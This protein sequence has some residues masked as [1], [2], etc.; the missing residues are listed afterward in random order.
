ML[1]AVNFNIMRNSE[2]IEGVNIIAKY[3]PEDE[4]QSSGVYAEHDQFW[5][6]AEEWVTD[7]NDIKRLD[8][9]GWFIDECGWSGWA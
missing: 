7:E 9:L 3:I 2:F 6:G 8:E 4:K 5:F 1:W